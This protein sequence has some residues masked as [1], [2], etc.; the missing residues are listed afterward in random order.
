MPQS[1]DSSDISTVCVFYCLEKLRTSNQHGGGNNVV[2]ALW[3]ST[4]AKQPKQHKEKQDV[5][6]PVLFLHVVLG[7]H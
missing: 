4:E 5:I 6:L 2:L 7:S 1:S 3:C